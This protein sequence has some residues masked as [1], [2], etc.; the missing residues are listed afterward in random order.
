M[1]FV[2]SLCVFS[3]PI[4]K[5][6][7]TFFMLLIG[8]ILYFYLTSAR[9]ELDKTELD[10]DKVKWQLER[11]R[12]E[13]YPKHPKIATGDNSTD[14]HKKYQKLLDQA[15]IREK[16]GKTLDKRHKLYFGSVVKPLFAFHVFVSFAVI[17]MIKKHIIKEKF[18]QRRYLMDG[19]FKVVPR[20]FNQLLIIAIEYKDKVRIEDSNVEKLS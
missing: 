19:T 20:K 6:K 11:T 3:F 15:D 5:L 13:Q 12:K 17:Q 1:L 9:R 10:F 18:Q 2:Y 14:I 16:Y 4:S 7:K 8:A